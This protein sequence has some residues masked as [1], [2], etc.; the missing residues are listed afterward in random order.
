M[1]QQLIFLLMVQRTQRQRRGN[2]RPKRL[3]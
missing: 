3:N 1:V 2:F